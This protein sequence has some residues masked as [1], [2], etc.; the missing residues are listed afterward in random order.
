MA[1]LLTLCWFGIYCGFQWVETEIVSKMF[2]QG[3]PLG[4]M[5]RA[6]QPAVPPKLPDLPA[7]ATAEQI[8]STFKSQVY[9]VQCDFTEARTMQGQLGPHVERSEQT[10]FGSAVLVA[11]DLRQGLVVTNRHVVDPEYLHSLLPGNQATDVQSSGVR[12][13]VKNPMDSEFTAARI[14]AINNDHDLALLLVD[15]EW[16]AVEAIPIIRQ[17]AINQ[18]EGAVALGNPEGFEFFTSTGIIS[19]EAEG[20]IGTTC[21]NSPGSSGGPLFLNRHGYLA[22]ISVGSFVGDSGTAQSLNFAVPAEAVVTNRESWSW[23]SP[24]MWQA[25]DARSEFTERMTPTRLIDMVPI[26]GDE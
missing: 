15:G 1:A 11:H 16:D 5:R 23:R 22:G 7:N 26:V 25:V 4:T 8:T 20:K 12:V 18:G 9:L 3:D 2:R 14:V 19:G 24:R 13:Q 21:A 17:R 10:V 6:I